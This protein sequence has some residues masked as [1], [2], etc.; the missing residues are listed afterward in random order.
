[1]DR[2][3]A[4]LQGAGKKEKT[5]TDQDVICS[6]EGETRPFPSS[7][8]S[9]AYIGGTYPQAKGQESLGLLC[10]A[11]KGEK[12]RIMNPR[13][14]KQITSTTSV[15]ASSTKEEKVCQLKQY[16]LTKDN[17]AMFRKF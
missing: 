2:G 3:A 1:M 11:E 9:A 13:V 10:N 16:F 8:K 5:A 12:G 14:N 17:G 6:R 15:L 4:L 7:S